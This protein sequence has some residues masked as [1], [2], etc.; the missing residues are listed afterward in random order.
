MSEIE[1]SAVKESALWLQTQ[2]FEVDFA[3][4]DKKGFVDVA[5]FSKSTPACIPHL[6]LLWRLTMKLAQSSLLKLFQNFG[7]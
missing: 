7:R 2:G 5:A 4:V 6:F 3:P 1:H